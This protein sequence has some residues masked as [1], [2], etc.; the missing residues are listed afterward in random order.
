MTENRVLAIA[1]VATLLV[2]GMFVWGGEYPGKSVTT[3]STEPAYEATREPLPERPVLVDS[4]VLEMLAAETDI[5]D[6]AVVTTTSTTEPSTTT[7]TTNQPATTSAGAPA[8]TAA[9]SPSPTSPTTTQPPT[10]TQASGGFH[11]G[12]ESDFASRINSY[13]GSNGLSALSRSGSLDSHARSWAKNMA[14]SGS[15]SHSNI[16]S[17]LGEWSSVGENVGVG[18][19]VSAIFGALADSS[20]HRANMLGDFT[21]VGIGVYQASDGTLWTCHV[22][23]R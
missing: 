8:T 9:P 1:A 6:E 15:L 16:G 22:F 4:E 21:H 20:G 13:R 23:A 5:I 14:D 11:S 7:T 17:L 19:N 10:T 18:G 12:A 3:P 2:G